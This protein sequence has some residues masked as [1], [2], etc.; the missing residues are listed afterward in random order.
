MPWG[1][2][3]AHA[4][5]CVACAPVGVHDWVVGKIVDKKPPEEEKARER[6][7]GMIG[8]RRKEEMGP[9]VGQVS[10]GSASFYL[11]PTL[12]PQQDGKQKASGSS[13]RPLLMNWP[14]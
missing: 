1:Y 14:D 12:S 6:E 2:G 8:R 11:L 4:H 10:A 7:A 9:G 5:W 3:S 13:P